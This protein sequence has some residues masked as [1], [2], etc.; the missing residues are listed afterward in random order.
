MKRIPFK[1]YFLLILLFSLYIFISSSNLGKTASIYHDNFAINYPVRILTSTAVRSGYFPLWDHWTHGGIPFNT[2]FFSTSFS[3]IIL[4]LSLFGIYSLKTFFVEMLIIFLLGFFGM[5][6]WLKTYVDK[7]IAL[8]GAACFSLSPFFLTQAPINFEHVTSSFMIPWLAYG[9]K[10]SLQ[11]KRQAIPLISFSLLIMFTSG[12]LGV[13][14][15]AIQFIFIFCIIEYLL[16]KFTLHGLLNV[17]FGVLLFIAIYNYPI[18]ETLNYFGTNFN[19]IRET[20]FEPSLGS[21]NIYSFYTIIWPNFINSFVNDNYGSVTA[22]TYFGSINFIFIFYAL[23]SFK[24]IKNALLLFIFMMVSLISM[25]SSKLILGK[26]FTDIIPFYD[27]VRWHVFYIGIFLFFTL[28]LSSIGLKNW[29]KNLKNIKNIIAI[30]SY[31]TLAIVLA[32]LQSRQINIFKYI[33]YPQSL[34]FLLFITIYLGIFNFDKILKNYSKIKYP[35]KPVMVIF[36][37]F[38]VLGEFLLLPKQLIFLKR[39]SLLYQQLIPMQENLK[40]KGFTS[41]TNERTLSTNWSNEQIYTKNPS[42][43][44][45]NTLIHPAIKNLMLNNKYAELIKNIFYLADKEGNPFIDAQIDIKIIKFQPNYINLIIETSQDNNQIVWSSPYTKNWKIYINKK[46][47]QTVMNPYGL[48]T[49]T[50]NNN[51]FE[52]ELKYK[53]PYLIFSFVISIISIFISIYLLISRKSIRLIN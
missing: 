41:T 49:F 52:I 17:I 15:I 47:S 45:Y 6:L 3:P 14:I 27:K 51:V 12:Y 1:L 50:L 19:Q 26:F 5:F 22:L 29:I 38:I 16:N 25:L 44:G 39:D 13:N 8:L 20:S 53:P 21:L 2:L 23:L 36:I 46:L 30:I 43:Y 40:T 48:T 34:S 18:F 10:R 37:T 35:K 32:F 11:L 28:T 42:A 9:I 31:A 33:Y 4:F 7:Y 24:K